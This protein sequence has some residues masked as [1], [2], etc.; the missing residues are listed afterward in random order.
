MKPGSFPCDMNICRP[1][2][3]LIDFYRYIK[4]LNDYMTTECIPW[5]ISY[6]R[7]WNKNIWCYFCKIM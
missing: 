4:V 3:N 5:K 7:F 2:G 6:A 1:D